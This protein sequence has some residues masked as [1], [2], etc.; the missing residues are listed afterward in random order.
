MLFRSRVPKTIMIDEDELR[1]TLHDCVGTIVEA[2]RVCVERTPPEIAADMIDNG[3]TL[4]GGG[5]LLSGLDE[6]LR[7]EMKLPVTL[8]HHPLSCVARGIGALFHDAALLERV[9]LDH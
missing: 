3:I 4:T 5:A 2:V 1:E 6:I 9:A 7:K 8:V